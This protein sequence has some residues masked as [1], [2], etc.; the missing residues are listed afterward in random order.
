MSESTKILESAHSLFMKIGIKSVSMD[1][2]AQELCMS[3]KTIYKYFNDKKDLVNQVIEGKINY[4][5]S[6]IKEFARNNKNAIQRMIDF[7]RYINQT[8]K[9]LNPTVLFD[10]EKFYPDQWQK[11]EQ[12]RTKYIKEAI[13]NNIKLGIKSGL[14]RSDIN[15][16]IVA[17]MYI[18]LIRGM[19]QQLVSSENSYPFQTINF[20]MISYHLHGICTDKGKSYLQEHINEIND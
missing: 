14:F 3:K 19:M 4:E 2:I 6:I 9:N 8:K 20:Q 1:I 18:T 10:M 16:D 17:L 7:S 15:A 11:M 13:K 12:F 5:K